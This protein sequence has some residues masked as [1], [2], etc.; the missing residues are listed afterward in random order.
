MPATVATPE[1]RVKAAVNKSLVSAGA[2][3]HCAVQNGMGAPALDYHVC[4]HGVYA[5]IE[6]KAPGK[7][8]TARQTRTMR[9]VIDA[10]GAVFLIDSSEG[11]D[12]AQLVGWLLKPVPGFISQSATVWLTSKDSND[13]RDD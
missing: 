6:T 13:S 4:H 11:N 12:M 7:H 10:G 2:Y 3:R 1:G 9:D 5:G 8:P